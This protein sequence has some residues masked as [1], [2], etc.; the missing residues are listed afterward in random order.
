MWLP[1]DLLQ[2]TP[3]ASSAPAAAG[4]YSDPAAAPADGS[5]SGTD[6]RLRRALLR[7]FGRSLVAAD[8]AAA[9][10]LVAGHGLSSVT[11]AGSV[12]SKWV[13]KGRIHGTIL[14]PISEAQRGSLLS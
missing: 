2:P 13:L 11:L 1:L 12:S 14:A 3:T 10:A 7:A 4:P 6:P 9:A 8:D 5:W